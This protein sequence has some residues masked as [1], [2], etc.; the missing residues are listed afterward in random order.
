MTDAGSYSQQIARSWDAPQRPDELHAL[1]E[2]LLADCDAAL[3][4]ELPDW[5]GHLKA[6]LV[7]PGGA[8]YASLTGAGEPVTWRG[9]LASPAEAAE[10][11]LYAVV[12][13]AP[14]PLVRAAVQAAL[15]QVRA[16]EGAE[17]TER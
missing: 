9:A 7:T 5:I 4:A 10:V 6:L 15:A 1:A 11:T 17:N 8:A 12:W 16:T 14:E 2:R 13:G 3:R